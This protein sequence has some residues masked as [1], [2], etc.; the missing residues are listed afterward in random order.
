[1][2]PRSNV[3]KTTDDTALPTPVGRHRRHACAF[4]TPAWPSRQ[5]L[6]RARRGHT[7]TTWLGLFARF[8]F[9]LAI[10]T[11][12]AAADT[13]TR[14]D[15]PL[16]GTWEF[17]RAETS[18]SWKPIPVPAP[19]ETTEG[20][21]FDGKGTYRLRTTKPAI[22][23]DQRLWLCFE[24]VATFAEV[25]VNGRKM[26]HHLGGWTPFRFD[27]T[28]L[29]RCYS[30]RE[31]V[32]EVDVDEKVGHNSQG[33]LP[34]FAPHF[35]GIWKPV[36]LRILPEISIDDR[37]VLAVGDPDDSMW[38]I[39]L[40]VHGVA[41]GEAVDLAVRYRLRGATSWSMW[42]RRRVRAEAGK[43]FAD[44]ARAPVSWLRANVPVRSPQLW[45]PRHP[46]LYEIEC[47]VSLRRHSRTVTDR[48]VIAG[49]F[50]RVDIAGDTLR[51][52]GVP[53]RIRGLLNWGYAPPSHAP[54]LK[55]E[56]FRREIEFARS[57]GFN[58]M[59]FCLW[60]PPKRYLELCDEMGMLAWVEYPTWHSRWT[61]DQLPTLRREFAEFF[62]Y[63]RNHPSVVLRSLTCE[64]GPQADLGVITTLYRLCHEMVPGAVVEDDS[65]WIQWNRVHDFYDDHPYGN[66]HTWVATLQRLKA[67][68]REH[69]VRP[70]VLGECMAADTWVSPSRWSAELA[71]HPRPFWLPRFLEDNARWLKAAAETAGEID[72]RQLEEDSE[73]Y[74][75]AMRKYQIETYRRE[76]PHGGY[77]VSVIRDI[78]LCSM[79]LLDYAGKPK[80]QPQAWQ[81]HRDVWIG[82]ESPDDCRSVVSGTSFDWRVRLGNDADRPLPP[83]RLTISVTAGGRP[84]RL[85]TSGSRTDRMEPGAWQSVAVAGSWPEVDRPT[86]VELRAH[87]TSEGGQEE[88]ANAWR[89]WVVPPAQV[90]D[91]VEIVWDDS[92]PGELRGAITQTTKE[93]K[94]AAKKVTVTCQMRPRLWEALQEGQRVLWLPDGS[95]KSLPRRDVW[96]LRGGPWVARHPWLRSIPRAM[97]VDLQTF[98]L[99]A[100]VIP[101]MSY[102]REVRPLLMLW[103]NHDLDHI[104]THGILFDVGVGRGHLA[105]SALRHGGKNNAA[106][107]WLLAEL[108]RRLAAGPT[109][110][111]RFSQ[112]R[113]DQVTEEL[114][115]R[116]IDLST[117]PWRFV[118]D[119]ENMG[120]EKGWSRL[121][122]WPSES[123]TIRIGSAWESQGHPTLD[124]WAWYG[125]TVTIPDDWA[126]ESAYLVFHGVDD[127]Y[128]VY[129]DG[130]RVGGGG[131]IEARRT[132]FDERAS[133]P[134]GRVRPGQ[135]LEIVV[136]VYDWYG[137]GGIFRPVWLSN[138]PYRP[139][140]M[141]GD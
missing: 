48:L 125:T 103:H 60:V 22:S 17:R 6:A 83:G 92:V 67:Y 23:E 100:P 33:F 87:W 59:K 107:R 102:W 56:H 120:M 138:L 136:R 52:N 15:I 114:R 135:E 98:D 106:G 72:E 54:S 18:A 91:G 76:V 53:L 130:E 71:K 19:F 113:V 123:E 131:D 10:G 133:H 94:D 47:R 79:G 84:A 75:L 7:P 37:Y 73:R 69:G 64:T 55:E 51:L 74:A 96:F 38:N 5:V 3:P 30:G 36:S 39:A 34:V 45:S 40:P 14:K 62:A 101:N 97:L 119:A 43:P 1:M 11:T 80:W 81:W 116:R 42:W 108:I 109:A 28:E 118:V 13:P 16:N 29:A 111:R 77:V 82:L 99:A 121:E 132:A 85:E 24:G 105:V 134:I 129:V 4:P 35:G 46:R 68:I 61:P 50:R 110:A 124:G 26:G 66:N 32:I 9:A 27:I 57:L 41:E 137:A 49:A 112:D 95:S 65:S 21:D 31:L 127:Y 58:T 141:L 140:R 104:Q 86:P 63:D 70:L 126:G 88:V 20:I 44:G 12:A 78:P 25:R 128:E 115:S 90:E 89:L 93:V 139:D 122:H 8:F 117:E 2:I